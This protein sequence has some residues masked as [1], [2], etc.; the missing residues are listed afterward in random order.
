MDTDQIDVTSCQKGCEWS[1]N[2]VP[3]LTGPVV[4]DPVRQYTL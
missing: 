4:G 3:D 2:I 1:G